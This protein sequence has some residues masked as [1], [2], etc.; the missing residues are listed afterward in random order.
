MPVPATYSVGEAAG[1]SRVPLD[2]VRRKIEHGVLP[3]EH[4]DT[5]VQ[6]ALSDVFY[7]GLLHRLE[8]DEVSVARERPVATCARLENALA[9]RGM[10][11]RGQHHSA[12][13]LACARAR[14]GATGLAL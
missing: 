11:R 4:S 3:V 12:G 14:P 5:R 9:S 2:K 8:E 6:L 7:L 13:R 10:A 1:L